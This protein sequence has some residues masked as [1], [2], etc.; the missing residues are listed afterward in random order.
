MRKA[1][2]KTFIRFQTPHPIRVRRTKTSSAAWCGGVTGAVLSLL[3]L[4]GCNNSPYPPGETAKPILFI[5][6][7]EDPKTFDPSIGYDVGTAVVIDCIYPAFFR[8]HF[9][10]RN[11]FVLELCLGAEDPKREKRM[12]TVT[13][14]K[15]KKVTQEGEEW[16]FKIKKGLRFQDDPCFPGGK[17]REI[18]GADFLYSFRRMANPKVPCPIVNYFDDKILGMKEYEDHCAALIKKKMNVDQS[19]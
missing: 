12:V 9:L 14:E 16:T 15:G 2:W 3:F 19:F 13:G 5:A 18:K 1:M 4:A 8:Y 10:K 11:P 7:L 6:Q 17:G